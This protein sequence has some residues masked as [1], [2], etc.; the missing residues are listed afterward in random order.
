M[1]SDTGAAFDILLA[2]RLTDLNLAADTLAAVV[3]FAEVC[4]SAVTLAAL[5]FTGDTGFVAL[6][7]VVG[8]T[9]RATRFDLRRVS[10]ISCS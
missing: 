7:A 6:G 3:A 8:A 1:V 4:F 5:A 9:G 10:A 2:L